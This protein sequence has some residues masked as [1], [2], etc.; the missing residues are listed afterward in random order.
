MGFLIE[1]FRNFGV[2]ILAVGGVVVFLI[3]AVHFMDK[4]EYGDHG[5]WPPVALFFWFCFGVAVFG[6]VL[7][8]VT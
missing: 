5:W 3:P 2:L 6:T 4:M 7:G 1:V 8:R